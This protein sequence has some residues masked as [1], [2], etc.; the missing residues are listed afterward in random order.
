M[1]IDYAIYNALRTRPNYEQRARAAHQQMGY[2]AELN[3]MTS[4]QNKE[5][6]QA[7]EGI[8][9]RLSQFAETEGLE[10]DK[11][12][13]LSLMKKEEAKIVRGIRD[14]GGDA[15]RYI[16]SGGMSD[17]R[18]YY[19]NIKSSEQLQN[20][21][22]NKKHN[23]SYQ[24][25]LNKGMLAIPTV[26][27]FDQNGEVADENDPN[28]KKRVV[29]FAEQL[30]LY[31]DGKIE[32]LNWQGAQKPIAIQPHMF[33]N[34]PNPRNPL[35]RGPVKVDELQ[36]YLIG[37]GQNPLIANIIAEKARVGTSDDTQY[38][39][40]VDKQAV[41]LHSQNQ[42]SSQK[43]LQNMM[44][45]YQMRQTY[46]Q[47]VTEGD[48]AKS[49]IGRTYFYK[50][51]QAATEDQK[52]EIIDQNALNQGEEYTAIVE[53]T[54]PLDF[55][56]KNI[57][58]RMINDYFKFSQEDG[59]KKLGMTKYLKDNAQYSIRTNSGELAQLDLANVP[60]LN[61]F[62]VV[63]EPEFIQL[64]QK[65]HVAGSGTMPESGI[66]RGYYK[67]R[68]ELTDDMLQDIGLAKDWM[69]GEDIKDMAQT[70]IYG[71]GEDNYNDE[72]SKEYQ[73]DLYL[74]APDVDN[75]EGIMAPQLNVPDY[76]KPGY[77]MTD[78][79]MAYM[80]NMQSNPYMQGQSQYFMNYM[81]QQGMTFNPNQSNMLNP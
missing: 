60:N 51:G 43:W 58:T 70:N 27:A 4:M 15:N 73:M 26:M 69:F 65:K 46:R 35:K 34:I 10:R 72:G 68:V 64:E 21:I 75:I 31:E 79:R 50:P 37:L 16:N 49:S 78:P 1:P 44:K 45:D 18:K 77:G 12:E 74:A 52:A 63:G 32:S 59:N 61:Y 19:T 7:E 3:R 54:Y 30:Q 55:G 25:A 42:R 6:L 22:N 33:Q 29:N 20:T 81:Q 8:Q 56:A 28:A 14:A 11:Q 67:V 53:K 39:Y 38:M 66:K 13:L 5:R 48:F 23:D 9:Q 40:G 71:Q 36:N 62:D 47:M 24:Q 80:M 57:N 2:L 41:H 17:L 76:L